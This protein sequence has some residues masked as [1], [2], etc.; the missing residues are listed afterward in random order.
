MGEKGEGSGGKGGGKRGM[1]TPCPPPHCCQM[2]NLSEI[3]TLTFTLLGS[4]F[5][6]ATFIDFIIHIFYLSR[7]TIFPTRKGNRKVQGVPQSQ[8]A[9]LPRHQ[10]EED[11]DKNQ[12]SANRTNVGKALR[13]ALS[14]P[15]EVITMLKEQKHKNKIT[16][17]KT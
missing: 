2:K 9:A 1:P 13:L 14:F 5:P 7:G 3:E 8:T 16:Q 6:R 4:V 10:E 12:T 17:G 11:I 15:S